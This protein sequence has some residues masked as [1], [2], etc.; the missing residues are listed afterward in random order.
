MTSGGREN[1]PP[2]V[3]VQAMSNADENKALNVSV[4]EGLGR[5]ETKEKERSTHVVAGRDTEKKRTQTYTHTLS[6]GFTTATVCV[7][8]GV[9][10][11][12]G[13]VGSLY[14]E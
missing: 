13:C 9:G 6:D 1:P 14:A 12:F 7:G 10:V 11:L 5:Q 2:D 4:N 3:A 8:V